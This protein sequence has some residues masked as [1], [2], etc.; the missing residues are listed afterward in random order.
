M[1]ESKQALVI[2]VPRYELEEEFADLTAAVDRDAELIG[3]A[4]RSSGYSVEVLG[5]TSDRPAQRSRIRSA[6]SRICCTAPEDGTVLVHFT[7]HGL[8]VG[9]ADHLVPADAQL[10]W[11]TDPPEVALDS[12]IDL[13]LASLLQGC[14]AGTVLLTVDACRDPADPDGG[15]HGGRATSFPAG[16]DRVAVLFGCGPG[17]TCGSDDEAG[18]HFTRALAEAL[19]ADTSPRTV[20]EV[21][22]YTTART[23][24]LARAARHRQTPTP[25]YAPS[26][27]AAIASATLCSG[28]TRQEAWKAAVRDPE[29]WAAVRCDAARR[30]CVQEALVALTEECARWYGSASAGVQDP[31]ADD[32]YPVRVLTRGLRPLLA[33]SQT[34]GGPL[35]DAGEFAVLAAA[36]F[37]REALHALG[38]KAAIGADAFRLDPAVDDVETQT[39]RVDLE[40]TFAAHALIWRKGR[41]LAGRGRTEE[42]RAVAA[43]LMH[44]HVRGREEL[45]DEAYAAQLLTPLATALIGDAAPARRVGELTDELVRVCRQTGVVPARS[46]DEEREAPFRLS[47]LVCPGPDGT[48]EVTESWRPREL[49]W[50]TAVSGLL[51]GDLRDLPGVL[52]DNIGVTDGLRPRQA[53]ESVA[54]LRWVRD[55]FTRAVDLDL[56]CPHPA[57]HAGLE[58]LTGWTDDAVLRIREHVGPAAP[59]GLLAHLP[60]RVTCRRLRPQYDPRTKGDTYGVPLMRFGLAEDEM[61]E[62]L[63]GTQLYGDKNLALRELYQNALD[64]CRYREARLRYGEAAK[65]IAYTWQGEIVFRQGRDADGRPYV[66]CEDNGVGMGRDTLRGTFSRAG[67]RFEQSREYRREQARWRR[68]D[69]NLRIFPNSRFGVGVFSYFMLADEISISTRVTDQYGRAESGRG[70][71]VDI[72][73][74]GSLFR[75]GDRDEAQPSGGTCVRLYLQDDHAVDVAKELGALVWRSDFSMRVERDGKAV[76][77]WKK[78]TLYYQGDASRAVRA[79]RDVWWVPGAGRLLADG[80]LVGERPEKPWRYGGEDAESQLPMWTAGLPEKRFA[81]HPKGFPF[82]CVMDLRGTRAPEISTSRTKVFSYDQAWVARQ[83]V[84][85]CATFEPPEWLTLEWLWDFGSWL[86]DGAALLTERLLARDARLTSG[87][88]WE[89]TAAIPFRRVGYFPGDPELVSERHGWRRGGYQR[90]TAFSAWRSAV[91][92]SVSLKL[93]DGSTEL[94][95]PDTTEGYPAPQ[96]WEARI[97][98]RARGTAFVLRAALFAQEESRTVGRLLGMVRRHAISGVEVPEVPDPDTAAAT[99]LDA[100]DRRLLLGDDDHGG[101]LTYWAPGTENWL[102]PLVVLSVFSQRTGLPVGE[103]LARARRLAANGLR[104]RVPEAVSEIPADLVAGAEDLRVLSWHPHFAS[105]EGRPGWGERP[106]DTAYAAMLGHYAWLGL[107]HVPPL[108]EPAGA[109]QREDVPAVGEELRAE[110]NSTFDSLVQY[111][112]YLPLGELAIASEKLSL[113]FADVLERFA[114]VLAERR[115]R[116]PALGELADHVSSRLERELLRTP[117]RVALMREALVDPAPLLDTARAVQAVQADT[118]QVKRTLEWLA[119]RGLVQES[120][121][122]FVDEWRRLTPIDL[123][124]LPDDGF[125][126]RRMLALDDESRFFSAQVGFDA[127]YGLLAAASAGVSLGTAFERLTALG[128][129][130]GHEVS[131]PLPLA[132]DLADVRPTE[133]DVHACCV[134]GKEGAVWHPAPWITVLIQHARDEANTLGES[135]AALARYAPLG[136]PWTEI[137]DGSS[138][139]RDHRPTAHDTAMFEPD[140]LG[141]RPVTALDL[142][143]VA[144]RFGRPLDRSWDHVALYRPLGVRVTVDRPRSDAV[145][146]WQ[147]LIL[148]TERYTGRAPALTGQVTADRIAVAARE[149]EKPTRW[150]RD[151]YALYAPLFGLTLPP[152]CPAEPAP[153]PHAHPYRPE[154][155]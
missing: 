68:A 27:P 48:G 144:G 82:G 24:E 122:A 94:P 32:D 63:M 64:A 29:L 99:E 84:T 49:S 16:H 46:Y 1:G 74:S 72:A 137:T 44:R 155:G 107:P 47:E 7:G 146:V 139:W 86:P 93:R 51:G 151:R 42:A 69:E 75:I 114:P 120:A 138:G 2:A 5:L 131:L 126:G 66:E 13:D 148:L 111:D 116:A 77:S 56:Q 147:D 97:D 12:L 62:L 59:D 37:V 81:D 30:A 145:P 129:V 65:G 34:Q 135:L 18:S 52:V 36:P 19:D 142:L 140:L 10:S 17:Q 3:A 143:R 35:I 89:R 50:L 14:R 96:A 83:I 136:A 88:T 58:A 112:S 153:T 101:L 21:I 73:S 132:A 117:D 118:E 8:S 67:R 127:P 60:E 105:G 28:R 92:R 87:L 141:G 80:V 154:A 15:S 57:V 115:V 130:T 20:A 71:R 54:E 22:E 85:A 124:L 70:L 79:G 76:R 110:F 55:R 100:L 4:L 128:P 103:A 113:T 98:P 31:W 125:G 152:D 33:P 106:S 109:E 40:H 123:A 119:A 108:P 25:H 95:L 9:G 26:G 102:G 150:V 45:W 61:R 121:P 39:D 78:D 149:V 6:I 43:W 90:D 41:E 38:V 104:L 11:A 23:T 53:V 133:A 134:M 91:L